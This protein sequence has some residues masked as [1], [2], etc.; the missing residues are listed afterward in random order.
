ML[1][2]TASDMVVLA[3]H[4][5]GDGPAQGDELGTGR[6]RQKPALRTTSAKISDSSTPASARR[7]PVAGSKAMKRSRPAL[8]TVYAL[9]QTHIAIAAPVAKG[10]T[11]SARVER[12]GDLTQS[13]TVLPR[14]RVTPPGTGGLRGS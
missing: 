1:A 12:I 7:M 3:M 8:A 10:K 6:H 9:V 13:Q 11:G 14:R 5:V 4:V 2:K